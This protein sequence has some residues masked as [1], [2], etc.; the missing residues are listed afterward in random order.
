MGA[1]LAVHWPLPAQQHPPTPPAALPAVPQ[2]LP[3]G[4]RLSAA[5]PESIEVRSQLGSPWEK[6][7]STRG[8]RLHPL[9]LIRQQVEPV[10]QDPDCLLVQGWWQSPVS[11]LDTAKDELAWKGLVYPSSLLGLRH[12][13]MYHSSKPTDVLYFLWL[14]V[15]GTTILLFYS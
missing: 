13:V 8:L 15:W 12:R 3:T 6:L 7:L 9:M 1:A 11:L 14:L 4:P 2:A 5:A 10:F